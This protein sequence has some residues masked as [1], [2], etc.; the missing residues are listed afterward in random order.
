MYKRMKKLED[1]LSSELTKNGY[2]IKNPKKVR[3]GYQV[4]ALILFFISFFLFPVGVDIAGGVLLGFAAGLMLASVIVFIF[5]FIMPA[6]TE[7][8]VR[9]HD[10]LL[11]LKDYIKL[12]EADRLKFLQSPEGAEKLPVA[13]QFDPKTP[14]AKV[15][16]FE[17]LLPYA[18]LFGLEK[19]WAKQFEGIYASSPG[20][21][22]GNPSAFTAGYLVGSIGD[23]NTASMTSFAAPSSS[24]GSGFSGGGAGGGGGGG[25]GG[26]W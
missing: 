17:K 23:F 24:S 20:W 3:T 7:I 14:E 13:D 19:D 21:Y 4:W 8:G 9:A 16:L 18:M 2:F 25:G 10:D 15:K 12:A 11:G 26:G 22:Q 5:S 1:T 6:R